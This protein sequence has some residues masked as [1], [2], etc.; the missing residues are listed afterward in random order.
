MQVPVGT[1]TPS[2]FESIDL[3]VS[4]IV[5]GFNSLPHLE[6]CFTS[7]LSQTYP[8]QT[9]ILFVDNCSDDGSVDFVRALFPE[10]R[11]LTTSANLGYAGGNNT[12]ARHAGG[13]VL[14][15]LNPD[16]EVAADWLSE[17][18][19]PLVLDASIG[20]TTSKVLMMDAPETIN[21]CGN[22]VSL[23][24][25]TWCRGAGQRARDFVEDA[26]VPAIS[27]CSFAI[28][29]SLFDQLGGFDER[30]FMYL[31]DTDL[32]WRARVAGY[33]CRFV[34]SSIVL[35]DYRLSLSPWKIGLIERNRYRMLGK[36]LSVRGVLALGPALA[37]AEVL[38]WGYAALNGPS[39][40]VAKAKATAWAFTQIGPVIRTRWRPVEGQLLREHAPVPPVIEGLG[41]PF[42]RLAQSLGGT[43]S[44]VASRL[45]LRLLPDRPTNSTTACPGHP[46]AT[47][48]SER[49]ERPDNG[50]Q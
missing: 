41:G 44:A 36:H 6:R 26:D 22:S 48:R 45:S 37:M 38:T 47:P 9:E 8:G 10:V 4:V 19:R 20:L 28:R 14:G 43:L 25:I 50:R 34:A 33:R 23:A 13:E 12:G 3:S 18:V 49:V 29:A 1:E 16:T 42:A 15:F 27:G 30:F 39:Y 17:L 35:H 7:L 24:G 2:Q 5:V 32:S 40:L 11:V 46:L 21:T 31:E